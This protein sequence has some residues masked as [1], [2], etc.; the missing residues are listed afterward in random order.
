MN[1]N[2]MKKTEISGVSLSSSISPKSA[3]ATAVAV[4]AL[5]VA[6]D[7]SAASA[8]A[9]GIQ[10]RASSLT[11]AAAPEPSLATTLYS[12]GFET[13][14]N[15]ASLTTAAGGG[16]T[17]DGSGTATI[18]NVAA[19]V[20]SGTQAAQLTPSASTAGTWLYRPSIANPAASAEPIITTSMG[21][22]IT[23]PASGTANRSVFMG[24]QLYDVSGTTYTTLAGAYLMWNGGSNITGLDANE[25]ALQFE[26]GTESIGYTFGAVTSAQ[27]ASV[28]Y[29]D[30]SVSL[31]YSTGQITF[32]WGNTT[33]G[34]PFA[35]ETTQGSFTGTGLF[36]ADIYYQRA[37][38]GGTLPRLAIDNFS[39][40]SAA[41][42]PE[43]ETWALMLGGLGCIGMLARRRKAQ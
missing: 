43:P 29:F 13:N 3:L 35:T 19:L 26:W 20:E 10:T 30:V 2:A 22:T 40:T 1:G 18:T 5:V 33:L 7:A 34:I 41:A 6:A 36:E 27:L 8:S 39:I 9:M 37:S 42:V 11:A 31:D 14:T 38:T 17:R 21:M 4:L 15:G 32:G 12:T 24:L 25:L 23:S 28:G 16:W